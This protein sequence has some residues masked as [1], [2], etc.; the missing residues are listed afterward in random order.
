MCKHGYDVD[1]RSISSM[2]SEPTTL[3]HNEPKIITTRVFLFV[4][5]DLSNNAMA[6]QSINS[7]ADVQL[8]I[9]FSLLATFS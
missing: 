4:A 7:S 5:H 3:D 8:F 9:F 6:I 2:D 1:Y